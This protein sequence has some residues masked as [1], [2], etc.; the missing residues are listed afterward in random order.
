MRWLEGAGAGTGGRSAAIR[1]RGWCQQGAAAEIRRER[2]RQQCE[3]PSKG[4]AAGGSGGSMWRPA[5]GDGRD[6]LQC[7]RFCRHGRGKSHEGWRGGMSPTAVLRERKTYICQYCS[8]GIEVLFALNRQG[9]QRTQ[10]NRP[11]LIPITR[12]WLAQLTEQSWRGGHTT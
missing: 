10:S 2:W 7:R 4:V 3:E 1:R 6:P 5:A 11:G 9:A 12:E 8:T